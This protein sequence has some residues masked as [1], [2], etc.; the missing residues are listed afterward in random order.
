MGDDLAT[1]W[2][3]NLNKSACLIS[4]RAKFVPMFTGPSSPLCHAVFL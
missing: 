1:L 4:V 3:T 2:L